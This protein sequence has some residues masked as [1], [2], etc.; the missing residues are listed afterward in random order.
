M[1]HFKQE[2]LSNRSSV[3]QLLSYTNE[4]MLESI[5]LEHCSK[6][7]AGKYHMSSSTF[8]G[9]VEMSKVQISRKIEIQEGIGDGKARTSSRMCG[10][11]HTTQHFIT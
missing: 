3:T 5:H 2:C 10:I 4:K 6:F 9:N 1:K 8:F 7:L 11:N